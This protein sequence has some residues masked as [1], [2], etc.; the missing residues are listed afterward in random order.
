MLHYQLSHKVKIALGI[1]YPRLKIIRDVIFGMLQHPIN[2]KKRENKNYFTVCHFILFQEYEHTLPHVS[3]I[4]PDASFVSH[5]EHCTSV[6]KRKK[7]LKEINRFL[8]CNINL[9]VFLCI[10]K[11]LC[12]Q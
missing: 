7:I 1:V 4:E 8:I 11:L 3:A 2:L 9:H 5:R 10:R 12:G 6:F